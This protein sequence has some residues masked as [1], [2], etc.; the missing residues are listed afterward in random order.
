MIS[1]LKVNNF[2]LINELNLS[3]DSG[4]S[5]ITG[6]TGSGKSILLAA[7]ELLM[8]DRADFSVIGPASDRAIVEAT[9]EI[10]SYYLQDF[11]VENDLDYDDQTILRREIYASGRSRAFI[12]DSPVQLNVLKELTVQLVNIHSQYNT[13]ELK[14]KSKQIL[15]FDTLAGLE[16]ERLDFEKSFAEYHSLKNEL[17]EKEKVYQQNLKDADYFQF[18]LEELSAMN[19]SKINFEDLENQLKLAESSEQL[20]QCFSAVE[21]AISGEIGAII[22]LQ[23]VKNELDK[24]KHIKPDIQEFS[25]RLHTCLIDL[26]ELNADAVHFVDAI[27]AHE[28]DK[29]M[30]IE[31]V[32]KYN[33]LLKKHSKNNQNELL[34]Y[35]NELSSMVN[36]SSLLADEIN[37]LKLKVEKHYEL[38]LISANKL[39]QNRLSSVK[40]IEE[41]LQNLLSELKLEQTIVKFNLSKK[42]TLT[43]QSLSE[44]NILF[45]ANKGIEPVSIEKAASGG[46][47]SRVMLAIQNLVSEMKALP[48]V[49]F[50]E[51]DTGVSGDVAQKIG[52]LLQKMGSKMQLIAIS[53]LPQVAAKATNHFKVFKTNSSERT[54]TYVLKLNEE[55][56]IEE[57][58]RLM[59]GEH[60]TDAAIETAKNLI[61]A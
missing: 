59:S 39:H 4:F 23:K 16:N 17:S 57:I 13:L 2:S 31:Q 5:V 34:D 14:N 40:N 60:I 1:S 36:D 25:D 28:V 18:Q 52:V 37:A 55:Q 48:T 61:N 11:F 38:A 53:H 3:L 56:R 15:L 21:N 7:L 26:K 45:S 30:L 10:K 24:L 43:N 51:I 44:L 49:F 54:Q 42:E 6:E 8:G 9:L 58:A 20:I 32:D 50:D 22:S 27:G 33:S 12:N 35:L 19:L 29:S 47:L 46:E 41:K